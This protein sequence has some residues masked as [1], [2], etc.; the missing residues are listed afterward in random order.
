[1]AIIADVVSGFLLAAGAFLALVGAVGIIRLPDVFARMHGAGMIDTLGAG[2]ILAGLM[3]QAGFTMTT[4]KLILIAIFLLFTTPTTTHAL[5]TAA[6]KSG[7]K[8]I[9]IPPSDQEPV[10]SKT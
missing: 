8:P 1:M 2:S 3:V 4:V 6:L 9:E 10:Q 7:L 5:A